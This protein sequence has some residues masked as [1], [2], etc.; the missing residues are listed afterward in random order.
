M[1]GALH[2]HAL[3]TSQASAHTTSRRHAPWAP[4]DDAGIE[5]VVAGALAPLTRDGGEN[6]ALVQRCASHLPANALRGSDR[7]L[8]ANRRS[9][10]GVDVL[11]VDG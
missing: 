4:V 7:L 5:A 10:P 2:G 1:G 11:G 9:P 8:A 3:C 6:L